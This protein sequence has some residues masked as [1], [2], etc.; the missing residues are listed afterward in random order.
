MFGVLILKVKG[1]IDGGDFLLLVERLISWCHTTPG[2]LLKRCAMSVSVLQSQVYNLILGICCSFD[3]IESLPLLHARLRVWY[4]NLLRSLLV[5]FLI[6]LHWGSLRLE[7]HA[8]G[9]R[10]LAGSILVKLWTQPLLLCLYKLVDVNHPR[11]GPREALIRWGNHVLLL[12]LHVYLMAEC[13]H[14]E[15][16]VQHALRPQHILSDSSSSQ[17]ALV[18]YWRGCPACIPFKKVRVRDPIFY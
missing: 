15:P 4:V 17:D 2:A 16:L 7:I 9:R 11:A 5:N 13:L 10:A 14:V 18:E 8:S 6:Y 1:Y 3:L 12:L